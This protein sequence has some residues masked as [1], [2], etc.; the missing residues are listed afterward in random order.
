[1]GQH[2][3]ALLDVG[4]L[5]ARDDRHL[6]ADF[7]H[8]GDHALGDQV[9]AHDAAEDVDQDGLDLGV[10]KNELERL[11][12]AFLG[13]AAADVQ[14]VG[15]IAAVQLDDVHGG[16]GKTGAVDHAGDVAVQ[17]DVVE[18]VL[19]GDVFLLVFLRRITHLGQVRVAEHGGVVE[20]DLGVQHHDAVVGGDDQRVDLDQRRILVHE[21]VVQALH[22]P[23]EVLELVLGDAE[24]E[25]QLAY[26]VVLQAGRRVDGDAEDLLRG[27]LGDFLDVH[28][29]FGGRHEGDALGGAVHDDRK[30]QL[31]R[32]V[33]TGFNQQLPHRQALGARLVGDELHADH[34]AGG[35][36]DLVQRAAQLD[37]AGLAAA[38][39]VDLGLHHPQVAAEFLGSGD[40]GSGRI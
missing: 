9:A 7:L 35:L 37:A 24:A 8:R 22:H 3:A 10:G 32:D 25:G 33:G 28:A 31:A 12:D 27:L 38:A 34:V 18:A 21:H 17:R 29:A 15:R 2:F 40:G 1:V 39:G 16:H 26:L 30:I 23:G 36:A 19:V 13:G 6:D 20:V 5:K 11:G 14:E 4:A